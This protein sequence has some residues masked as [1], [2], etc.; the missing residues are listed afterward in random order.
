MQ[1]APIGVEKAK[2]INQKEVPEAVKR[3]AGTGDVTWICSGYECLVVDGRV[4]SG[5]VRNV[6]FDSG[7][8]CQL[9]RRCSDVPVPN[10]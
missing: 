8:A 7:N 9:G 3:C 6:C 5:G 4:G 2:T 10:V 1:G